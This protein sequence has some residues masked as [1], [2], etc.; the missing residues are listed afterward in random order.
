MAARQQ[1]KEEARKRMLAAMGPGS[2]QIRSGAGVAF[3][4]GVDD[5]HYG[6]GP[7]ASKPVKSEGNEAELPGWMTRELPS[8][9]LRAT[10]DDDPWKSSAGGF[11]GRSDGWARKPELVDPNPPPVADTLRGPAET[12]VPVQAYMFS[13]FPPRDDPAPG[14]TGEATT[15]G[16]GEDAGADAEAR[17]RRKQSRYGPNGGPYP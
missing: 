17:R 6:Y 11:D 5:E 4:F 15:N 9:G 7:R 1:E 16:Q 3:G 10:K 8:G 2:G 12:S 13:D 14:A